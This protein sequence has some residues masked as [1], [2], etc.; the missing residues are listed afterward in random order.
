MRRLVCIFC[1]QCCD[2]LVKVHIGSKKRDKS[3]D[4]SEKIF[5]YNLNAT[6]EKIFIYYLNAT[7]HVFGLT[8]IPLKK[9]VE[10]TCL[11]RCYNINA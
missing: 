4:P 2:Q 7:G 10:Y 1:K 11:N 9:L 8:K 5:I 3:P 6:S